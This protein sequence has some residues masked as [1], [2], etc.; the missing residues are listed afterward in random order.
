MAVFRAPIVL[1]KNYGAFTYNKENINNIH[2][3]NM[4]MSRKARSLQK[5]LNQESFNTHGM[6][7]RFI[8]FVFLKRVYLER[9]LNQ[10]TINWLLTYYYT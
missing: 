10:P 5:L 9:H 2:K 4:V 7:Y 6:I 3:K 8:L 1:S